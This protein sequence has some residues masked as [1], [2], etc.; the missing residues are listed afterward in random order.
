MRNAVSTWR[1]LLGFD[2]I[3]YMLI[4]E[5]PFWW[6]TLLSMITLTGLHLCSPHSQQ[7]LMHCVLWHFSS[8]T[9]IKAICNVYYSSPSVESYLA[10]K[11]LFISCISKS[12]PLN[13]LLTVDF[14]LF[15]LLLT[16]TH[17][18]MNT[19]EAIQFWKVNLQPITI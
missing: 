6:W 4:E 16:G 13:N 7:G 1:G 11:P 17:H 9:L 2:T 15:R 8:F 19:Q 5:K 3:E 10:R 12:W 18:N 14:S